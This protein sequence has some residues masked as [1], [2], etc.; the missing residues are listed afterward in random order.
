MGKHMA[1]VLLKMTV[2]AVLERYE[3]S[4]VLVD[5]EVNDG[6]IAFAKR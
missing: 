6:K 3:I 2:V 4:P 1:D 5:G